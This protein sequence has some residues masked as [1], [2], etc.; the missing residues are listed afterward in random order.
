VCMGNSS[1]DKIMIYDNKQTYRD[2]T[3]QIKC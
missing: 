1:K 3:L 2:Y